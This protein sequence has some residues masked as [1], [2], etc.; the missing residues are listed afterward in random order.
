MKSDFIPLLLH[1]FCEKL[2]RVLIFSAVLSSVEQYRC[3]LFS[4]TNRTDYQ[5]KELNDMLNSSLTKYG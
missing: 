4:S 2:E 3:T 5:L 1:Y